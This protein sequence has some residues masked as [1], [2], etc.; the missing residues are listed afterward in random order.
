MNQPDNTVE[1][2]LS[3][4]STEQQIDPD[5]NLSG[6]TTT[7]LVQTMNAHDEQVVSAVHRATPR[8]AAAI[9]RIVDRLADGGRLIY[10]GAGTSG[11]LG[12]LDA[13]EI[14][15]TFG[16]DGIVIG[17]IAGGR[18]A[19]VRSAES[20]EDHPE[21]AVHDLENLDIGIKDAVF[22]IAA[23]GRTAYVI[24]AIDY[25]NEQGALTVSLSCNVNAAISRLAQIPLEIPVGAEIVSGSTRLGAGTA[26]KM[27][28][29]MIS[30]IAMIRL[31]KTYKT[32]M[33]DVKAT[34]QKLVARAIRI[35]MQTT[36]ADEKTV[37]NTLEQ[38]GWRA[39]T[40]IV[41]IRKHCDATA[42]NLLLE[43]ANGFLDKVVD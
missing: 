6:M 12:V 1:T 13:S 15:P 32:F 5:M 4:L 28:L 25:A 23:S 8:I 14:P 10:V 41:M 7:A 39:K 2:K 3:D 21:M 37:R 9:D 36:K 26:T 31:G 35:V 20:I 29:N 38:S 18:D 27:V 34:N 17:V 22:G 11:R 19:L 33:V 43:Q 30:T 24:G 40:A 42:A 16:A